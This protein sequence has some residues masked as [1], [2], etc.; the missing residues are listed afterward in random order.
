MDKIIGKW[1]NE[2]IGYVFDEHGNL[3]IHW[4]KINISKIG[5][6]HIENNEI[7]FSYGDY[8]YLNWKGKIN[9]VNDI[10]LSIT[11]L[12]NEK[13]V[14]D[15][16]KRTENILKT[17]TDMFSNDEMESTP[18]QVKEKNFK[19]KIIDFISSFLGLAFLTALFGLFGF[20]FYDGFKYE[21]HQYTYFSIG[22]ILFVFSAM[23]L[24]LTLYKDYDTD[25]LFFKFY[26]IFFASF[27]VI[28][29]LYY[30]LVF[31]F[32]LVTLWYY[33]LCI[34]III[35]FFVLVQNKE[36][37]W[38]YKSAIIILT[39]ASLYLLYDA[40]SILKIQ[41]EV[42]FDNKKLDFFDE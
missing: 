29:I 35:A 32:A 12:S 26:A 30:V 37:K 11:D 4:L 42:T 33:L 34:G 1:Q 27:L 10:E 7:I 15:I 2:S 8:P 22:S 5:S 21:S 9:Y 31:F 13:G 23:L 3:T 40:K 14:V 6:W 36:E 18:V 39:I 16:L 41:F 38:I 28:P 17:Q 24:L 20:L 19:T 25:N